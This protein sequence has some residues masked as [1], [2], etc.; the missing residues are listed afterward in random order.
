MGLWFDWDT[1][2]ARANLAKHGVSFEEAETV[3]A[4]PL[5]LIYEDL[6]HSD[7]ELREILIGRSAMGRLLLVCFTETSEEAVRIISSREP[8]THERRGYEEGQ[9]PDR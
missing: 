8:T 3:F 4:D 5:G 9:H 6:L 7:P 1:A 2:K